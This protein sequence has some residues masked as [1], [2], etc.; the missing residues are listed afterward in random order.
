M[1][2]IRFSTNDRRMLIPEESKDKRLKILCRA[3]GALLFLFPLTHGVAV[4]YPVVAPD[5][6]LT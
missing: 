1:C 6:A 3:S 2:A 5:G 4:G